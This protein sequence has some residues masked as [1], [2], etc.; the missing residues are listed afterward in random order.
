MLRMLEAIQS[1]LGIAD[2]DNEIKVLEERTEPSAILEQIKRSLEAE[3][4]PAR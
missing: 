2:D 3:N 4:S 1:K